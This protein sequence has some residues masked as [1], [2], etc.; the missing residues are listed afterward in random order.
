MTVALACGLLLAI[1]S[2]RATSLREQIV[3][4]ATTVD[5]V[6]E[7]MVATVQASGETLEVALVDDGSD[8][9]DVANDHVWTGSV[10]AAPSEFL[11]VTLSVDLDETRATAWTG[12]VRA[13][14]AAQ[15][16]IALEVVRTPDGT[17]RASRRATAAPGALSHAAEAMPL[18][19]VTAWGLLLLG[20]VVATSR[21]R[22]ETP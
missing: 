22:G 1:G 10:E 6:P 14:Q 18:M 13:G 2:T 16:E 21:P 4:H 8:P 19:A 3:V 15:V 17:L 11:P 12:T 5:L 7:R 9:A 20:V